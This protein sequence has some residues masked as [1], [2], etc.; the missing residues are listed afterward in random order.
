MRG[1]RRI[2]Q[3][4]VYI[5][6]TVGLV[7]TGMFFAI[8]FHLTNVA[9]TVDARSVEFEKI[10]DNVHQVLGISDAQAENNNDFSRIESEVAR[11]TNTQ[12]IKQDNA[13]ALLALKDIAPKD[14][15]AIAIVQTKNNT[16]AI[17]SKMIFA[18]ENALGNRDAI[19]KSTQACVAQEQYRT[20]SDDVLMMGAE[21][22][23]KSVF[24]WAQDEEW[25]SIAQAVIKDKD[26][27]DRVAQASDIEPRLIVSSLIVEQIRLFHSQRELF[28]K[29][30]EPLKI[31][32]NSTVISLGVM[33]IKP[34]TAQTVEQHLADTSSPFY[35]G[36]RY[37]HLLDYP[38]GIDRDKERF[39]RLTDENNHYWSYLYGAL[40]LKQ[41]MKQWHDAE[42]DIEYRPEIVGTLFNVGF[43][44]SH[45]NA[46]PQVGGSIIHI[47]DNHEYSFG[48]L[49]YEFYYSGQLLEEFPFT[50]K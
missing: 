50:I 44:Q 29:F 12:R 30:F 23:N 9:G 2:F 19:Q 8:R 11:L 7:F 3:G 21:S 46:H 43:P 47:D 35:L 24:V 49:A 38:E 41:M 10:N 34:P 26:V 20:V 32:G 33:G 18:L 31:L 1:A 25:Q 22:E 6:A 4:V 42:Y 16:D 15:A 39:A 37:V 40:Y 48:R 17:V 45:P 14:V 36:E 28:K 27:I 13:C 5:F